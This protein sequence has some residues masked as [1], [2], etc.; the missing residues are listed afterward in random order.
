MAIAALKEEDT[1]DKEDEEGLTE[2]NIE[3]LIAAT[4]AAEEDAK[5]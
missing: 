4:D 5:R 2:E 3:E 1:K